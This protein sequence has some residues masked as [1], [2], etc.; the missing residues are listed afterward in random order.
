MHYQRYVDVAI[1]TGKLLEYR[2]D[3]GMPSGGA[4]R[5]LRSR[6]YEDEVRPGGTLDPGGGERVQNIGLPEQY[7]LIVS[8]PQFTG[9]RGGN[10]DRTESM[11]AKTYSVSSQVVRRN[12]AHRY[13]KAT[14]L[15]SVGL[16][17]YIF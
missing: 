1:C 2:R 9:S 5:Y 8:A 11:H 16:T 10:T 12:V 3:L 7:R 6:S 17:S 4:V 13:N 14:T 15:R